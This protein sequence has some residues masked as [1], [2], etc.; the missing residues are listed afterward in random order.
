MSEKIRGTPAVVDFFSQGYRISG[1][2]QV[3][4][5]SLADLIY[6]QTVSFIVVRKAYLSP[7]VDPAKIS[8]YYT[9]AV[10]TKGNLDFALTRTEEEGLR[11]DQRYTLGR[12]H[13][14]LSLT[15]PFFE[16]QGTLHT[17]TRVF[18]PR[19]YLSQEASHFI[20]LFDVTA[21]CTFQPELNY[22]GGAALIARS[23]ISFLGERLD[24][25]PSQA[26]GQQ[27][28]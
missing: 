14:R 25:R 22:K 20:T 2:L 18:D 13:Y 15:V 8:A 26:N 10:M 11:R 6:D 3:S 24:N 16:I 28:S 1:L 12:Y 27:Q 17:T 4:D 19:V 9:T 5:R 23:K 21:W 7:I